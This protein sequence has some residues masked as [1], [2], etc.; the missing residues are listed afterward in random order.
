M[1]IPVFLLLHSLTA[2][3]GAAEETFYI[4]TYTDRAGS[5]GIYVGTLDSTSGELSSLRLAA[6]VQKDPTFLTLSP[7][8]HVLF[9]ALS[10]AVSSFKIQPD[11]T[12]LAL[13]REP[14]DPNTCHVCLDQTGR[15][16]FAASYDAGTIAAYPV[17]TDGRIGARTALVTLHGSGPNLERQT[18]PHA[19]AVYIDPENKFLYACDLGSDRIWIFR[20]GD[21]GRLIAADPPAATALAGSGPRHLA[22][23][24]DDRLVYVANEL[25]VSTSVYSRNLSTGTL[26]LLGTAA[27]IDPGWPKGTGSAEI[28]L[29]PSGRWL[30][31]STRLENRVTVFHPGPDP[32]AA[33][34]A[35]PPIRPE[36]KTPVFLR[37]DQIVPSPVNFPR[38]FAIDPTGR[39]LVIAGQKDDSIA[40][41][42]IDSRTGQLTPTPAHATVGSPVCVLF[43]S[44]PPRTN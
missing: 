32:P 13:N 4:G 1:S 43:D 26:T 3:A 22:F 24:R 44:P 19:H 28:F 42:K 36:E 35:L 18:S 31:V 37:R 33:T 27:N 17:G 15:E 10:N 39:W 7:D 34:S 41:L 38:S 11:G 2:P 40:V 23:G 29:H 9:A 8:R 20:L 12:L 16:L 25:G 14:A 6:A 30:Y 21:H 5:Q